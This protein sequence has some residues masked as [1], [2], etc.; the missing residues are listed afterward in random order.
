MLSLYLIAIFTLFEGSTN[1]P[2]ASERYRIGQAGRLGLW[3][4]SIIVAFSS[5]RAEFGRLPRGLSA[6]CS[7]TSLRGVA[8]AKVAVL[9]ERAPPI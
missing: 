4:A 2:K 1:K 5:L 7:R 8:Q 9:I 3:F 6:L